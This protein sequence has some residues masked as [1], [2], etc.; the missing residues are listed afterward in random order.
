M[1]CFTSEARAAELANLGGD[2]G[3]IIEL[4][5]LDEA[6]L[7]VD[8]RDPDDAIGCPE[9]ARPHPSAASNMSHAL[10]SKNSKK[11][12]LNTMPAGSQWPHSTVNCLW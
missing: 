12:L 9:P 11:R 6:R 5:G 1:R 3:H 8:Q 7:G 10:Q 2:V 4:G